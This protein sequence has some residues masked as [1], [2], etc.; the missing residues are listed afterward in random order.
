M[1]SQLRLPHGKSKRLLAR[2][3]RL[4]VRS[5]ESTGTAGHSMT[6]M[7]GCQ[8]IDYIAILLMDAVNAFN[9][10][11]R[12]SDQLNICLFSIDVSILLSTATDSFQLV[13]KRQYQSIDFIAKKLFNLGTSISNALKSWRS[14]LWFSIRQSSRMYQQLVSDDSEGNAQMKKLLQSQILRSK[15]N[16]SRNGTELHNCANDKK[17]SAF[18]VSAVKCLR[19]L[20]YFLDILKPS[21]IL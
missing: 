14:L 11:N 7:F 18:A 9:S 10:L 5:L 2:A 4:L 19:Y 8:I 17:I 13:F 16:V 3:T 6:Q 20:R 12:R 15:G 1:N 21:Q